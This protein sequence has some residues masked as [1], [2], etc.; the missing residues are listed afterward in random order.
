[1]REILGA[2]ETLFRLLILSTREIYFDSLSLFREIYVT[3][4][5]LNCFNAVIEDYF[6]RKKCKTILHTLRYHERMEWTRWWLLQVIEI[7]FFSS[8]IIIGNE[9]LQLLYE[10]FNF[11]ILG[12]VFWKTLYFEISVINV[13]DFF[14]EYFVNCYF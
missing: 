9:H 7:A 12:L 5:S 4:Q 8:I 1:M 3:P 14:I 11:L 6:G 13:I 2:R 10:T